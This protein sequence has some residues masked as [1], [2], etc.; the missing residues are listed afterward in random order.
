[1]LNRRMIILARREA[2][3]RLKVALVGT[4]PVGRQYYLLEQR[5]TSHRSEATRSGAE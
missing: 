2:R 1:M 3:R 4:V 5:P